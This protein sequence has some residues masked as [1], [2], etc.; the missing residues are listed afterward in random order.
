VATASLLI[1][2]VLVVSFM[3]HTGRRSELTQN[4]ITELRNHGL[5]SPLLVVKDL[6]EA[7][8]LGHTRNDRSFH[9]CAKQHMAEREVVPSNLESV[10]AML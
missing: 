6:S 9:F 1:T 2:L 10:G 7:F 4:P 3:M 5:R 8:Y